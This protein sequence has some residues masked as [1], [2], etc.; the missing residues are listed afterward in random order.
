MALRSVNVGTCVQ[1]PT[2]RKLLRVGFQLTSSEL[3]RAGVGTYFR[4]RDVV[5]LGVTRYQLE[6]MVADGS[7]ER[8]GLGLYRLADV[9][10]TEMETIVM[11]A[12][13]VPQAIVCL[14]SALRVHEI[15]TQSPHQ[16]WRIMKYAEINFHLTG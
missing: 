2:F 6:R 11:V 4:P 1:L 8:V 10:A 5:R 7:V 14:L 12:S 13:A 9:E 15:G 16:V 3:Q